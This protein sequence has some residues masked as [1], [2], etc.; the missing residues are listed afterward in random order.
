MPLR[1]LTK[2]SKLELEKEKAELRGDHRRARRDP[3]AT[4]Q[5]LR[6]VVSDEL[7]EV[8]KTY[9]T[10]RRTVLLESAGQPVDRG[11]RRSRWPTTR[12]SCCC[13]RAGLLA[14][15]TARR[16]ARRRRRPRP[17]TTWSSPRCAAT[18]RGQVG[19]LTTPG[20][21]VKLDV[22]DLPDA[23]GDRQR[24]R[25]CRAAPR[26]ASSSPL[27]AGERVLALTSLRDRL[28]GLA[29]GTRQGVVKRVNPEVLGNRDAW[30]VIRLA[31][32]DEVVG[33]VELRTGDERARASSP[34]TPSCCTSRR[35]R[36]R[37]QGAVRRRHRRRHAWRPAQRV[38]LRR[39]S[40]ADGDGRG[41]HRRPARRTA[42]PGTEP[43][44]VKVTPFAEY[45]AKG[46][47]TGGVRCHRF[48]KGEDTLVLA[49]AGP[50]PAR[51]AAASGAPVD[52]PD[53]R[54]P[55]RRLRRRRPRSRSPR[56]PGRSALLSGDG[57]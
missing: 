23:A 9:G 2:F 53:G 57:A 49:W 48:L 13:P 35:R 51:A 34:P 20:R 52:L 32:G 43:G 21:L 11:R 45:P 16:A 46:R 1:R 27:E 55:P 5:L 50:G 41:R 29:L 38:V 6:K 37:P 33:A 31:D 26:S 10:P 36:V 8:A 14:R 42:L 15:T 19:A 22:L 17:S 30:E 4:T 24:T 28:A 12:A 39:R 56:S 47:G 3:R 18:A 44:A 40:T 54:R 7:A 25:T